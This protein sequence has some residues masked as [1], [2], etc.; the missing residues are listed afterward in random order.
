LQ[1]LRKKP[2]ALEVSN[3]ILFIEIKVHRGLGVSVLLRS[4]PGDGDE[5]E[6]IEPKGP[7][8]KQV[9]QTVVYVL[10][11]APSGGCSFLSP[12]APPAAKRCRCPM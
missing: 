6:L 11:A 9:S 7:R 12:S 10:A 5:E 1:K 4:E 2:V 3:D 8:V